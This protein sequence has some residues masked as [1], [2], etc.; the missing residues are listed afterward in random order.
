MRNNKT[1]NQIDK[2]KKWEEKF[3]RKDLKY[4]TKKYIYNFQQYETIRFFGENI[5]T[6][7]IINIDEAEMDQKN[8]LKNIA[9]FSKKSRPEAIEGTDRKRDNL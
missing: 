9:E 3:K 5:Y 1:R 2:I 4:E 8:L 7:K 6:G